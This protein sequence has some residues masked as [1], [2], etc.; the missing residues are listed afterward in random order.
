MYVHVRQTASCVTTRLANY[1]KVRPITLKCLY[2]RARPSHSLVR[3]D[4]HCQLLPSTSSNA[5]CSF[6][7]DASSSSSS[8]CIMHHASRIM[9]H[10]SCIICMPCIMHHHQ[11]HS[12]AI[13]NC[14]STN[15]CLYVLV[16][17]LTLASSRAGE[18]PTCHRSCKK[19]FGNDQPCPPVDSGNPAL[20]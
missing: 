19:S 14:A 1:S 16:A 12:S 20:A 8:S 2:V 3:H 17:C 4:A 11:P 5:R 13:P 18:H 10:V 6:Y 15:R 7:H 9:Y